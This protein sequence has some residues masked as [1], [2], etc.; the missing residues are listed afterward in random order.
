M[1]NTTHRFTLQRIA[2]KVMIERGFNADFPEN[3][4][5][6]LNSLREIAEDKKSPSKDLRHLLWCSIDNEDSRDLDQLSFAEQL[7]DNKI[8]VL[9]AVADVDALV[10][11]Q[12]K[13]DIH[14]S[15]NTTSVYTT[16]QVFPMLPEKLS[17]DLTSLNFDED[18]ACIVIEMVVEENGAICQSDVYCASVHNY[19]RLDYDSVAEWLDGTGPMPSEMAKVKGLAENI[20]LQEIAAN[21]LREMRY[22]RGALD[23]E[24]IEARPVFDGESLCEMKS[25]KKNRAKSIIEDFMI[26]S[27]QITA[28]FLANKN[29]PSFRRIVR[30]PYRWDRI[31]Q[32][33]SENGYSLLSEPNPRSLAECMKFVKLNKPGRYSEFSM[34]VL[35]LL[36]GG[37]YVIETPGVEPT[38]HFGLAVKS[39]SHSTAP[40]RRYPDLITHRLLKSAISGNGVP[41]SLEQLESLA[42][43]CTKKEDDAK[44]VERQVEKSAHA[45]LLESRI[46]QVFD[47][48]VS[49]AAAKGTWVRIFQPYL[50]GKLVKGFEGLEV[51]HKLKAR[52]LNVDVEAG[53]IDFEKAD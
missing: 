3:V 11:Q 48:I 27:N 41:Y 29:Y 26:A 28:Q 38:G 36:G 40:N 32:L 25:K 49:G 34:S 33:A 43:H 22:E 37:D 30:S 21:N 53:F 12:S 51:G 2:R 23:F 7:P 6:E 5:N 13:L 14:A 24:T 35:K 50:E 8:K 15:Q 52:L 39:Y 44:K 16:A 31:V 20:K 46:G 9:V 1:E 4:L 18:R 17:T 42:K 19:A 45:L 47:G 10:G